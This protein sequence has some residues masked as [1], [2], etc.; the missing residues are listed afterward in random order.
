LQKR[1]L[2]IEKGVPRQALLIT[3]VKDHNDQ[4]HTIL[5]VRTDKG[6]FI[7]DNLTNDIW[8]W[9]ATGYRFLKRQ[10]QE[11]PNVWLSILLPDG[12]RKISAR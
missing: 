6:D 4:G 10:S 9:D 2:L 8:S 3:I 11:D 7:L 5:T 12:A 1:R